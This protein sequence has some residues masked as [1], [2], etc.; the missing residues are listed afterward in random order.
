[1]T[2]AEPMKQPYWLQRIEIE[3]DVA[4]RAPAGC[5]PRRR[6]AGRRR[7]R[8]PGSMP[9]QYSAISSFTVMPAG[10]RCTPGFTTRPETENER[11]PLRPLR[12]C[13]ANHRAPFLQDLAHPVQRLHVVLE[14]RASEETDL[15]DV[16]RAQ[17]RH[18]ALAFDRFDHRRLFAAD[19]G[20]GAAP[21]VDRRQRARRIGLQRR[22]LALQDLAAAGVLVAQV[23][24][25]FG[26]ADRP[27]GDERA[28]EEAV[29]IALEVVAVLE[30]AEL[31][32]VDVDRHQP[33]RRLAPHDAPLAARR[34]S[35]RRPGRA[36]P[37]PPSS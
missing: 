10:A 22:D 36:G 8:G 25:D 5:R 3:R 18:A 4:H 19:V 23:D 13:E 29:R 20:A 6:P 17:P 31:A 12:P 9:P 21:Q 34:E 35:P 16:R 15:R 2:A 27:R 14:R 11:S 26:D 24:V 30:R 7:T 28:F 37:S 1:M 33:R 32:F